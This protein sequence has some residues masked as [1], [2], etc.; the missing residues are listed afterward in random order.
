MDYNED[1]R[2]VM[3]Y[4]VANCPKLEHLELGREDVSLLPQ[5]GVCLTSR[6]T[7]LKQLI[8]H[9]MYYVGHVASEA[10][11]DIAH[12]EEGLARWVLSHPTERDIEL[13]QSSLRLCQAVSK[14]CPSV[15]IAQLQDPQAGEGCSWTQ[16]ELL[17]IEFGTTYYNRILLA[18]EHMRM[19][20]KL[21]P[22]I[23]F[24]VEL[25]C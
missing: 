24:E 15:E 2:F 6:L 10:R 22:D 8:F 13:N 19:F 14:L 3:A 4:F 9:V 1:L 21:R 5:G 20:K 18:R 12:S 17:R 23:S 7:H 16:M 25:D 11:E